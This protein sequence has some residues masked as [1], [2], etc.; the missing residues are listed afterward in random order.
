MK[1]KAMLRKLGSLRHVVVL[2]LPGRE[3]GM[4]RPYWCMVYSEDRLG[5]FYWH[6]APPIWYA[7]GGS[8]GYRFDKATE[9][10]LEEFQGMLDDLAVQGFEVEIVARE[11]SALFQERMDQAT[12]EGWAPVPVK[13]P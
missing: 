13:L 11:S 4:L 9:G 12:A 3:Q 5:G 2:S 1:V 7:K 6:A 10:T 8:A